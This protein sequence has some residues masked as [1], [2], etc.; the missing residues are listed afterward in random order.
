MARRPRPLQLDEQPTNQLAVHIVLDSSGS[1]ET[2][3]NDA[4]GSFNDYVARLAE[5]EPS[6]T[7]SLTTFG[8]AFTN[9]VIRDAPATAVEPLT[10]HSYRTS[11]GTP[12]FDAI[13]EAVT[14]LDSSSAARKVMVIITDGEENTSHRYTNAEIRAM[15]NDRQENARWLVLF[16]A[17]NQDA[18]VSG[19]AIG[20][21]YLG[22]MSFAASGSALRSATQAAYASTIR[23]AS[24]DGDL[25]AA[26]FT[27]DE[28]AAAADDD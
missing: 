3:R 6:A 19:E 24:S 22:S 25:D 18:F 7:V 9:T 14:L 20:T 11:G 26:A 10:I 15:L 12:L 5:D 4:I 2:M 23:Y 1:M 21:Q 13:G 8:G 27:D 17:A 28:R 16:L